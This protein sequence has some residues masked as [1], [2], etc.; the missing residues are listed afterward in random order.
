MDLDE[1]VKIKLN[2]ALGNMP[3]RT[4]LHWKD[5]GFDDLI[6]LIHLNCMISPP[7]G[8]CSLCTCCSAE[9]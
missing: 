6:S 7:I 5:N 3:R 1:S 4:S 8:P 2:S 9:W